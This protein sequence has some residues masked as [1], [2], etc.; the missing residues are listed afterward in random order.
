LGPEVEAY[1]A[2]FPML[3]WEQAIIHVARHNPDKLSPIER[4]VLLII[5]ADHLEHLVDRDVLYYEDAA[6]RFYID[7]TIIAAEIAEKLGLPEFATKLR[8]AVRETQCAELPVKLPEPHRRN[9]SVVIIPKS[10][11]K[12]LY[13]G[14]SENLIVAATYTQ[15]KFRRIRKILTRAFAV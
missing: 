7:H 6:A 8:L 10:C 9:G 1:V 5:F 13:V 15:R 12:R 3:Y 4:A 2:Q 14:L 11:R